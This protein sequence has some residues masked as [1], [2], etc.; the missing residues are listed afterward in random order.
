MGIRYSNRIHRKKIRTRQEHILNFANAIS[1]SRILLAIPLILLLENKK[2]WKA[3][4]V[5]LL[6]VLSDFLDG[7]VAR[8]ANVITN[9]GKLIDPIADKVC[10]LVVA[11][12][13]II[14]YKLP[15]LIFF[16]TLAM[17]DTFLIIIGV[18]LILS[19]EE[20][21]QSNISG[22]WFMGISTL[23]MAFFIFQDP[24]N[25]PEY[26]LWLSYVVSVI[27]FIISTYEYII[28][29]LRYFKQLNAK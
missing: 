12:Y 20:V 26:L 11:I 27:L 4:I 6:I 28:R 23:M 25:I 3:F 1:I 19:Q 24:L 17:R 13:L 29:Y 18:Y 9:F 15:F 2:L 7:Y 22:K 8:K 14:V 16:I 5:I 21:F 10:M